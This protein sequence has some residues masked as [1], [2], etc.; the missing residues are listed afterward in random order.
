MLS[1]LLITVIIGAAAGI[2]GSF[3]RGSDRLGGIG[4]SV[5][6]YFWPF[7][8][9]FAGIIAAVFGQILL[10]FV[11]KDGRVSVFYRLILSAILG[12]IGGGLIVSDIWY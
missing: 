7:Y 11:D 3:A 10:I 8:V 1:Q 5:Q 6:L 4:V 12:F 9:V 2:I